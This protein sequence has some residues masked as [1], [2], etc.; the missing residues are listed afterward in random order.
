MFR[1]S[2]RTSLLPLRAAR[3]SQRSFVSTVLLSKTYE[4]KTVAELRTE[5]RARGLSVSGNKSTLISRMQQAD[6]R[7]A[8]EPSTAVQTSIQRTRGVSSSSAS[9]AEAVPIPPNPSSVASVPP[10]KFDIKLPDVSQEAPEP[11]VLVPFVPDFWDSSAKKAEEELASVS[12]DS[13]T[14]PK[15]LV[16]AGV[17]THPAGGPT[18]AMSPASDTLPSTELPTYAPPRKYDGVVGDVL[19]DLGIPHNVLSAAPSPATESSQELTAKRT[20]NRPLDDEERR[21]AVTLLG[22][23]FGAWIVSGLAAP[24]RSKS[25]KASGKDH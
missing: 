10:I 24:S 12:T 1:V 14:T 4:D 23:L 22:L 25:K 2:A 16:V 15:I 21:G 17:S 3:L 9:R 20:L 7:N 6:V 13:S 8:T 5:L 11:P 18:Y 19:D